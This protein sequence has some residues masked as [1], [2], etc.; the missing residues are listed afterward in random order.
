MS[1]MV[2]PTGGEVVVDIR[3]TTCWWS[4]GLRKMY[5]AVCIWFV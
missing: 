5:T 4:L 1:D 2:A 3:P